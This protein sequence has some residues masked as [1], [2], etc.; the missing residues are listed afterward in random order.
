MLTKRLALCCARLYCSW[1]TGAEQTVATAVW[2]FEN[3]AVVEGG[4]IA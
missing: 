4:G 3:W 2:E 1:E